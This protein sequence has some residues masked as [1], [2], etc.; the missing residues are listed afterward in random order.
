MNFRIVTK[1][2][3]WELPRMKLNQTK[4][5]KGSKSS[6]GLTYVWYPLIELIFISPFWFCKRLIKHNQPIMNLEIWKSFDQHAGNELTKGPKKGAPVFTGISSALILSDCCDN[7]QLTSVDHSELWSMVKNSWG[8]ICS[9]ASINSAEF[10]CQCPHYSPYDKGPWVGD[11]VVGRSKVSLWASGAAPAATLTI[12]H[13]AFLPSSL[14]ALLCFTLPTGVPDIMCS[15]PQSCS[16][17]SR[18]S[19]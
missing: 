17:P 15:I 5:A 1:F 9:K 2:V 10:K 6:W 18:V 14:P 16:L 12:S 11:G 4:R 13:C 8:E 3:L 19:P 7:V